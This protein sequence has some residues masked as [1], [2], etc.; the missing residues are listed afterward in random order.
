MEKPVIAVDIDDVLLNSADMLM[1]DYNL[2][3]G[4]SLT[5]A[6]Y[7]SKDLAKLG[8]EHYDE[9]AVR[10]R[11][12][13]ESQAFAEDAEAYE[14]AVDSVARLA[15]YYNFIGATSRPE[16]IKDQTDRWIKKRFGGNI[17][18]VIHTNFVM[19]SSSHIGTTL[20][21]AEACLLLGAKYMVEDHLHHAIPAAE[22]VRKVF[23]VDKEWNQQ[24]NL[25]D[26]IHRVNGWKDIEGDL[27]AERI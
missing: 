20:T 25:P 10:F 8:V 5:R 18:H 27:L 24:D 7:Y 14:E 6:D 23:L 1:A 17:L 4:T 3:F 21:K 22:N 9:A 16:F 12:Y 2:R 13:Q 15:Q 11:A 26:N 19:G